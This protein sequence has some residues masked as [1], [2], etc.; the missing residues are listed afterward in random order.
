MSETLFISDLH[1]D[2]TR[3]DILKLFQS[4]LKDIS[5]DRHDALYVLGDLFELWIG[6]DHSDPASDAVIGALEACNRRGTP[7]FLLRGN[8]DFLLGEGFANASGCQILDDPVVVSVQN[9]DTL[10]THGDSL[11]TGDADYQAFRDMVRDPAWQNNFLARPIEDRRTIASHMRNLSLEE[12]RKKPP[13]IMDVN[14]TTVTDLLRDKGVQNMIHGHTHRPGVHEFT[15]DGQIA[16]RY[17]LGDW[18]N[19]G[20]VLHCDPQQWWLET[21]QV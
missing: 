18:Y 14:E 7:V 15:L 8:R 19:S 3:P 21:L 4:F 12:V 1:L 16:R 9:T 17:V 5:P 20:S 13:H 11:C 10:L 2:V 6:D